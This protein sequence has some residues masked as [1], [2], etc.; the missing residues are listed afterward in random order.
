MGKSDTSIA[1]EFFKLELVLLQTADDA[2]H[3]VK[4]LKD[5]L[6]EYDTRHGLHFANTSKSFMR[7]NIRVAKDAASDL[8]LVAD[9]VA[10][11]KFQSD[12]EIAAARSKMNA[13]SDAIKGLKVAARVYDEMNGKPTGITR[14][15]DNVLV[16][17]Y[18]KK[19][20]SCILGTA[21]TLE[22]VVKSTLRGSEVSDTLTD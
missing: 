7:G 17:K 13:A 21:D 20:E 3:C 9:Q 10:K 4:A 2:I 18:D 19:K 1:A 6:T 5:N 12:W 8:R 16:G 11:S 22:L 15:I 14:I